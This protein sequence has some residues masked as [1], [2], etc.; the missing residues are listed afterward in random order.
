M[1]P[2]LVALGFVLLY[3]CLATAVAVRVVRAGSSTFDDHFSHEDRRLVGALSLYFAVPAALGLHLAAHVAAIVAM[4]ARVAELHYLVFW[5]SVLPARQPALAPWQLASVAGAGPAVS[6]LSSLVAILWVKRAPV[7]AAWNYLLLETSRLTLGLMLVWYPAASLLTARGDFAVLHDT[8]NA[9]ANNAGD[10][11]V[12]LYLAGA[13]CLWVLWRR[14]FWRHDY[15]KLASPLFH[16]FR[17][18]RR[19]LATHPAD[20]Q[21]LVALAKAHLGA[22]E[23]AQ[24]LVILEQ[25][26]RLAPD[27]AT[28]HFLL[29]HARTREGRLLGASESL[30]RAGVLLDAD[31]ASEEAQL[32][33]HEVLVALADVR[34]ALGDPAGALLTAREVLPAAT[35]DGRPL[36]L[37]TDALIAVGRAQ[38]A[39]QRLRRALDGATGT[40]AREIQRRLADL[41]RSAR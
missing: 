4:D 29:G 27:D 8:L 18:A 34:L 30:R 2:T 11:A 36:L 6:L 41:P 21:A 32:L 28:A 15:L 26:T 13:A 14:G 5:E 37:Y 24:A 22:E 12:F 40:M 25:A 10:L 35:Q 7:N 17:S 31:E 38:E 16:A 3:G 39:E 23:A 19:R 20:P 33:R 1:D 9:S